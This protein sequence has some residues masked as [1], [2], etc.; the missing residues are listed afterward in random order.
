MVG[1]LSQL[2]WIICYTKNIIG[3]NM[4]ERREPDQHLGRYIALSKLIVAVDL[5][6]AVQIQRK[7]FLLQIMIFP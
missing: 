2:F 5:L 4:V 1:F 6:R 3:G 7:L